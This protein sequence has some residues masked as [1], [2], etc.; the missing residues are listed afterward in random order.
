MHNEEEEETN[1]LQLIKE[2]ATIQK[3]IDRVKRH[4]QTSRGWENGTPWQVAVRGLLI[5]LCVNTTC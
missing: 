5:P 2:I 1:Y 3:N 4:D